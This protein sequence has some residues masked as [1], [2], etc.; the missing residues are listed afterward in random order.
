M[1]Y[2]SGMGAAERGL[3]D[4]T[5]RKLVTL[6]G[7]SVRGGDVAPERRVA[8][9]AELA[10]VA[11]E[12]MLG[13]AWL[14]LLMHVALLVRDVTLDASALPPAEARWF[15]W[16]Y[17]LH[18][19]MVVAASL[20]V[21][22]LQVTRAARVQA[23]AAWGL[24]S[25]LL[26]WSGL[27]S[28]VDQ[29]IGA[30]IALFLIVNVSCALF[31]TFQRAPTALAFALG[32]LAFVAGQLWFLPSPALAF[33]QL[34]NGTAFAFACWLFSRMLYATKARDFEQR[35]TI[36]RQHAELE[37]AHRS[38]EQ[39]RE[40]SERV[41]YAVLPHRIAERLRQGESPIA[42]VHP[43]LTIL[44]ADLSGFT[45]MAAELPA[46]ETVDILNELFSRFDDVVEQRGLEKIKTVGDAYIAAGGLDA[47][48]DAD[49]A[50]AADAALS[51]QEAVLAVARRRQRALALRV[52]IAR[53]E[54]MAGV[55]GRE[56]LFYDLWGD[57]V[58]TASRL[59]TAAA[60]GEVLIVDELAALLSASHELGPLQTRELKGKGQVPTRSILASRRREQM[61]ARPLRAA[62]RS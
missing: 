62:D 9:H 33:S 30:G 25:F 16:L 37:Q 49:V 7:A 13:F 38:M 8:F 60:P 58:N 27:V 39:E 51:M 32:T 19:A 52:G 29:L 43:R 34:V 12:R 35:A 17:G 31:V 46:A 47:P 2:D 54:V 26:A 4:A 48:S 23:V 18:V 50:A 1:R 42:D 20:T 3:D 57:A 59:E 5:W 45:H 56:R 10:A 28:G 6:V 14:L 40:R 24:V 15:A 22:V 44:F 36:A 41:L 53:G 55:L 61:S 11:R 21:L